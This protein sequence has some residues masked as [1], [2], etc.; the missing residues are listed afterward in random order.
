MINKSTKLTIETATSDDCHGLAVMNRQLID[1]GRQGNSMTVSELENRMQ[2][3][4]EKGIYTGYVFKLNGETIGY[5]LVDPSE[6]Y[7]RHFFICREHRRRGYGRTAVGLLFEQLGV[8]EI[9]LSCLTDNIPG[10]AFWRS[11]D[12]ELYSSK[13]YIRNKTSKMYKIEIINDTHRNFI[14]KIIAESWSGPY[15][16]SRG[17]LHDTRT[18]DGFVACDGDAIVGYILYNIADNECEITVVESLRERQGIGSALI[19]AVI[20]AAKTADCRRVWLITTNDNTQAL[21]FYQRFG[22]TLCAVYINSMDSARK[23]KPQIPLTGNDDIP[24]AHEFELEII[25]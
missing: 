12:H 20:E 17:I 19:N 8:E 1:E 9:G 5:T 10:Q 11:F 16:V 22:F 21:R 14:S 25:I 13:F 7:L 4:F 18:H 24:I 15:V 3:W 23:L 6:M 2:D